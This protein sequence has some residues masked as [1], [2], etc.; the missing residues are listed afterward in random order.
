MDK[1]STIIASIIAFLFAGGALYNIFLSQGYSQNA[2]VGYSLLTA[3][4][5]ASIPWI[6][7]FKRSK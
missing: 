3:L 5:L 2:A 7:Y 1:K 4:V 6:D